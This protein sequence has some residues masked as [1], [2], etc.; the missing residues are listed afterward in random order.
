MEIYFKRE[1]KTSLYGYGLIYGVLGFLIII[2]ARFL[3]LSSIPL[4]CPFKKITGIPCPTCGTTRALIHFAHLNPAE[5]LNM[6][7]LIFISFILGSILFL[8]SI[9]AFFLKPLRVSVKVG[10]KE[11]MVLRF[12]V[13]GVIALN[14]IYLMIRGI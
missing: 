13:I 14:W 2:F 11:K 4:F 10:Q 9:S 5:S 6:N 8:Y 12:G 1:I 7:P 3:P